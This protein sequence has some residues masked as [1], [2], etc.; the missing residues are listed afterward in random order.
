MAGVDRALPAIGAGGVAL[1]SAPAR[2][3][4]FSSVTRLL[5]YGGEVV[6]ILAVGLFIPL[7]ILVVGVPLALVVRLVLEVLERL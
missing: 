1:A 4:F 2:T 3:S 6:G 5:G 7:A